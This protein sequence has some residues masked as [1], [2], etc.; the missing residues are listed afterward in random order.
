MVVVVNRTYD[1]LEIGDEARLSRRLSETDIA[2]F[3]AV[4]G[5]LNPAHFDAAF[6][7][8][9]QLHDVAAHGMWSGALI[10]A[11]LGTKLPGPGTI[12]VAQALDFVR[13][14]RIGDEIVVSAC[15]REK[16]NDRRVVLDCECRNQHDAVVAKGA[17]TVVAPR[18]KLR[19]EIEDA[20]QAVLHERG[21]R[22]NALIA[23]A[24][25]APPLLAGVVHP[26]D[27]RSLD[28]A[29][30]AAEAGIVK[31]V[32]I[33]P[34]AKIDAA[35]A[36]LGADLAGL[37]VVDA[38]HSHAAAEEATRLAAEGR[39]EAIMKGALHTDELMQAV[40]SRSGGLRTD[41]RV[42]HVYVIDTPAYDKLLFITD[43]AVNID[44]DLDAKRD[45]IQNAID[46]ARGLGVD[47]PKVAVLSAVETV[48]P[49]VRST[50]DAAALCKMA[51]RGQ[52][53]G[54]VV[55][56]PLAFDNAISTDAAETKGIISPVAGRAD[57]L[58]APTLEAGN[59]IAKQLD[60]LAGA[61]AAGVVLGARVPVIL[62]SRA[63]GRQSRL[64]SSAAASL[65][66]AARRDGAPTA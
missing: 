27:P 15:V 51:D 3:G 60:Y 11:L 35:A 37:D 53:N 26:V 39:L 20:P 1:E 40:V 30:A 57:I 64:A 22:L 8:R 4:S 65:F 21:D 44:P 38:P 14:V 29:L 17:A 49:K 36:A 56:G 66:V 63:E 46:L 42:S 23:R 61:V 2:L 10:S 13:P 12:Y 58:V 31:P 47:A 16:L 62:T 6:A 45:I 19:Y 59:M 7:K 25:A 54:G 52:I 5:D 34:R 9:T 32:L 55:D 43:A 18:E 41:R 33:G 24:K 50:I 28:G 48:Y